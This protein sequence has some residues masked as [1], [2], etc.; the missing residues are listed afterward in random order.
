M[1]KRFKK[2][3]IWGH[4]LNSHTHSYIHAGFYKAF[5]YLG[6]ETIWMSGNEDISGMNFDNCLFLTEGQVDSNIP[7]VRNSHYIL[8]NT[9][10]KKYIE[11]GGKILTIQVYTKDVPSRGESINPYTII[12]KENDGSSCLYFP[13]ASDLLP[14]E[15][16][17]SQAFNSQNRVSVWVG[18]DQENLTNFFNECRNNNIEINK[19]NPWLNPVS[20]SENANL[21]KN[22]Y[23][24]PALQSN[25]QVEHGY[26]PC[27]IFKNISYGHFG[28]TNSS[29][30]NEI[31]QG[32]LVYDSNPSLLFYKG[33][34]EKNSSN[35]I[36]KLSFLMNEVKEKHTYI[37]RIE[38][39]L[40]HLPD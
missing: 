11:A 32:E 35:H 6:Y 7:L 28:Y 33:V 21:I 27:R 26:I 38:N 13:W 14:F 3:V 10:S 29:V 17:P 5:Q 20:F 24:S 36:E 2:V 15:I 8:H 16:N 9:H 19:I 30:V 39:I 22:S 1:H 34:E 12:Q 4:P 40:S 23:I 37:N 18:T 25:W 31:F